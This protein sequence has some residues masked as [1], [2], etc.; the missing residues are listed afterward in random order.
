MKNLG[1]YAARCIDDFLIPFVPKPHRLAVR[2]FRNVSVVDWEPE[3][4][5]IS[6]FSPQASLA[7]DVGANMGLWTYAMVRS[8]RF[9]SILAFEPNPNLTV[10]LQNSGFDNVTLIHKALSSKAGTSRLKIPKVGKML[11]GGWA[12]L[13][14]RID[15]NADEFQEM[16]VETMRLDDMRLTGVGF[17]KIDV[18]GHELHMLDGARE[19]FISNRPVCLIECWGRNLLKVEEFFANLQVGYQKVDT[20]SKYGFELSGDNVLFGVV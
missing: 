4:L 9:A 20:R 5:R 2:Y 15:I 13:E 6:D 14:N 3:I 8:G 10:D 12:S 19:L 11:L 16:K 1:Y 18:E 17:I 7:I